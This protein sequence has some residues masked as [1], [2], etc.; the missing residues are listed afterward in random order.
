[1]KSSKGLFS[2]TSIYD[3]PPGYLV[4]AKNLLLTDK[5][6]VIENEPGFTKLST[7]TGG[8]VIGA[9]G[10]LDNTVVWLVING[11]SE[12]GI[13]SS[14]GVYTKVINDNGLLPGGSSL[15]F[16]INAPIKAEY[17][18]NYD[19]E[20]IVA[21]IDA[22]NT[23]KI[24]NLDNPS[25]Q[26]A[27]LELF[28]AADISNPTVS[29]LQTGGSLLT[30]VYK[31]LYRYEDA[32]GTLSSYSAFSKPV[33]IIQDS[34]TLGTSLAGTSLVWGSPAGVATSKG[35]QI[36]IT[37][38]DSNWS[39][40]R[41]AVVKIINNITTIEEFE[42]IA[43]SSTISTVYTGSETATTL[44]FE[45][46]LTPNAIYK[47]AGAIG[48]LNNKLYLADLFTEE[49]IRLQKYCLN[50][51]LFWT[52]QLQ[53][54]LDGGNVSV[55]KERSGT[56]Y[57]SFQ[58]GEV[59]A[60]YLQ[61]RDTKTGL[62]TVGFHVPGL[63][64][65]SGIWA[66]QG[67]DTVIAPAPNSAYNSGTGSP[68]FKTYQLEDAG[69]TNAGAF[70]VTGMQGNLGVWKNENETYP[71]TDDFDSSVDY[72]DITPLAGGHYFRTRPVTHH[73]FPTLRFMKS[74]V[75]PGVANY[76]KTQLDILSVGVNNVV[77][78]AEL[79]NR[80]SAYRLVYAKRDLSNATVIGNSQLF[81]YGTGWTTNRLKPTAANVSHNR[82]GVGDLIALD[83]KPDPGV[84][85][86]TATF[87]KYAAGAEYIRFH[88]FNTQVDLSTV[89]PTYLRQEYLTI[90]NQNGISAAD[91][92]DPR[93]LTDDIA[94]SAN[95][96]WALYSP[97]AIN[98]AI[99]AATQAY[100]FRNVK[101]MQYLP[102]GAIITDNN[103][104]IDHTTGENC[105]LLKNNIVGL[106][107]GAVVGNSA[108]KFINC[109]K[110]SGTTNA[111]F[112]I[113]QN[114]HRTYL[115]S[116]CVLKTDVYSNFYSQDLVATDIE[117]KKSGGV[118]PTSSGVS[119][120]RG[121]DTQVGFHSV[122]TQGPYADDKNLP[123]NTPSND[124]RG[125]RAVS[126]F[127]TESPKNLNYRYKDVSDIQSSF[128]SNSNL[129]KTL[130]ANATNLFLGQTDLFQSP[131]YLYNSDYSTLN[132]T[133]INLS[134]YN[135]FS[136]S[137]TKF[138]NTI[139]ASL[140]A[141]NESIAPSWK[142][143]LASDRYTMPRNRGR[144]VNLQGVGNQKLYIHMENG[145]F[146]TKDRISLK[147]TAADVTLGSGN[148]FDVTPFEIVSIDQGYGGTQNKFGCV[149]TKAGYVFTDV[150][151]GKIFIHTG[152]SLQ[153]ISKNGLRQFWRDNI[154]PV[155]GDNPFQQN[156]VVINYDELYNRLLISFKKTDGT[157]ITASYSPQLESWVSYHD[158]DPD[159]FI[160]LRGNKVFSVKN[161]N[162]NA[163]FY[164]HNVG[165][166][167]KYYQT[168]D[169]IYPLLAD[170]VHNNNP[171][172]TKIF[173]SINWVTQVIDSTNATV[174]ADTVDF[175][176]ARSINKTTG[177]VEIEQYV[178]S[179][180][181]YVAN[182]RYTE[183]A[184][185]FN[186]FRD[187]AL[188][189]L[190]VPLTLDF[191]NN[192]NVN[193]AAVDSNK[194]WYDKGRFVD[195]YMVVR[196]EYSNLNNNK[197]LLLDHDVESR[198]S[199]RA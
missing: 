148:I 3:T 49:S 27:D 163:E 152:E 62:W 181:V 184:W 74:T 158:Y 79:Q 89:A 176:T 45:E 128:F 137:V 11:I 113:Y 63:P 153:E 117:I 129:P 14:T 81:F 70:N 92:A 143:F 199:I 40:V 157:Y 7:I 151:Q 53:S 5:L 146:L 51:K 125:V 91:P 18:L 17:Y 134:P 42:K 60:F 193:P 154:D 156:G 78:P 30:G 145:L 58:H 76:G 139:A 24:I 75:Y 177:K 122:Q 69:V 188:K 55:T 162:G 160:A 179:S 80:F 37:P 85:T 33:S 67:Y 106:N 103:T 15:N 194:D 187:L 83:S 25:F 21:W 155:I 35:I 65:D 86:D 111:L 68:P 192:Y 56:D 26:T 126:Y 47:N 171:Y 116:L 119:Y 90:Y 101:F 198:N 121:G 12:I 96:K 31:I 161:R 195:N 166:Y 77:L 127:V 8:Q 120:I 182:T 1:M 130:N 167:G 191:Y 147:T 46:V 16:S 99:V 118:L 138:P 102:T 97:S 72:D 114:Q 28:P 59:Y 29:V 73:K 61:F 175:I 144:I 36:T 10:I 197:F 20:R 41:L 44:T 109:V 110:N 98:A 168:D 105:M 57:G 107:G 141:G 2:D 82:F 172:Q 131:K 87:N 124:G 48:Q 22:N 43:V 174:P 159:V 19:G 173:G 142:N 190:T 38:T 112:H 140:I 133:G 32:D 104:V 64:Y 71:D 169:S 165:E 94:P 149:L 123:D 54:N 135:P 52:S 136:I 6:G 186:K 170:V 115:S 164:R 39:F 66:V 4:F 23:P 9:L 13:L 189:P 178:N 88:A 100:R 108:A 84:G 196:F 185:S 183:T 95:R 50:V 34:N 180:E 150:S 132:D 93:I